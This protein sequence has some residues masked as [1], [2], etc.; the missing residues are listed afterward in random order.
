MPTYKN[1]Y[2]ILSDVREGINEH[3]VA[4]VN[5]TDTSGAYTNAWLLTQIN[6]AQKYLYNWLFIRIPEVFLE[7]EDLTGVD[8]VF[9]LPVDFGVLKVFT[10]DNYC[11]VYEIKADQLKL[12]SS[13]GSDRLYYRKGNTLVLD[14]AGVTDAYRLWYYRRARDL[15][16]GKAAAADTLATTAAVTAD[17]YNGMIIED[18]TGTQAA[19]I[20]DYS[21]DREITSDITLA[22]NSYYGIVSDLPEPFHYLIAPKAILYV[23]QSPQSIEKPSR[24]EIDDFNED[25]T[26]VYRAYAK[27]LD[28][29]V[30][31]MF[32]DFEP[33]M[34]HSMGIVNN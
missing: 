3:S 18:I 6:R 31:D 12:K 33:G 29:S 23:K 17:Y 22:N 27:T 7:S 11:K 15:N 4:F 9:T 13:T 24:R 19:T 28:F 32:T 34:S 8:S 30:S 16:Q 14:K 20:T 25:F 1:A 26:S 2:T 5:A 21:T 10:D